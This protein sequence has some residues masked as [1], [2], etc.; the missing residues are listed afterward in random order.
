MR[1]HAITQ[2]DCLW[3]LSIDSGHFWETIWNHPD[4]SKLQEKRLDP[5]VLSSGDVLTIPDIRKKVENGDTE[6]RHRF[7]R[8]GTPYEF[9]IQ[10]LQNGKPRASESY[11][12]DIDGRLQD[13]ETDDQGWIEV[14]IPPNAREGHLHMSKGGVYELDLGHLDP[15]DELKGI[16]QRLRNLG[17]Y[18][19]A[20]D[21]ETG[22]LTEGA[23]AIFQLRQEIEQTGKL[24]D[25]TRDKLFSTHH[26]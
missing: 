17:F 16:Q 22:P 25:A 3:S 26:A 2:G 24:N 9:R 1:T 18:G 10:I 5:N 21:G 8:K 20:I 15:M 7:R 12:L 13:G 4:N 23:I 6:Q 11:R 14:P 19:G